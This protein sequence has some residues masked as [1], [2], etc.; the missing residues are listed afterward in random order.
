MAA[1]VPGQFARGRL[2]DKTFDDGMGALHRMLHFLLLLRIIVRLDARIDEADGQAEGQDHDGI[3]NENLVKEPDVLHECLPG[4][5]AAK[6]LIV[7]T[8][9]KHMVF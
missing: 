3:E 2:V 8:T 5:S 1:V 9:K 7:I 6:C 4:W